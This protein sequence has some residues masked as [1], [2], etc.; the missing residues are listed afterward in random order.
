VLRFDALGSE[1]EAAA[2]VEG[3]S[4]TA[5]TKLG[6]D[7]ARQS[8]DHRALIDPC[9]GRHLLG[10]TYA[11]VLAIGLAL[12]QCRPCAADS[13]FAGIAGR[14]SYAGL[15]E[16]EVESAELEGGAALSDQGH[17]ACTA[18]SPGT[19]LADPVAG[20]PTRAEP[21]RRGT[22]ATNAAE[23]PASIDIARR[24]SK[25]VPDNGIRPSARRRRRSAYE[26]TGQ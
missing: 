26:T 13:V 19:S 9:A 8:R 17:N 11:L 1:I 5:E 25:F 4:I 2:R 22:S 20:R 12:P 3:E 6:R 21:D 16:R 24:L 10:I 7:E 15:P 14:R 23:S 18:H